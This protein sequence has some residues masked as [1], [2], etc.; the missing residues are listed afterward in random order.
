[1]DAIAQIDTPIHSIGAIC[2]GGKD[3]EK[4]TD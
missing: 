1:M 2:R 4:P 3:W